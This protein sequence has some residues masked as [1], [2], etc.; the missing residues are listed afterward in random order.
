M[1]S[2]LIRGLAHIFAASVMESR[3]RRSPHVPTPAQEEKEPPLS[4]SSWQTDMKWLIPFVR[5]TGCSVVITNPKSYEKIVIGPATRELPPLTT[6]WLR[7]YDERDF[8][9]KLRE[10]EYLGRLQRQE[11]AR[12]AA[13]ERLA[14]QR[15]QARFG[16][17]YTPTETDIRDALKNM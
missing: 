17:N 8:R 13:A 5:A 2:F 3:A 4:V 7:R 14:L 10:A 12:R 11:D 6:D 1:P 15:G 16:S 9:V